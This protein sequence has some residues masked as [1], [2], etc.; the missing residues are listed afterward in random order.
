MRSLGRGDNGDKGSNRTF[1]RSKGVR[2]HFSQAKY[3]YEMPMA[4]GTRV[5]KVVC[6]G[7]NN[8]IS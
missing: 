1:S 2:P 8:R 3:F 7:I 4:A 6:H 5:S